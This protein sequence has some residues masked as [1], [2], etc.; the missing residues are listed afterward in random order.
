M[1]NV[2]QSSRR[3]IGEVRLELARIEW[4]KFHEFLGATGV[5]VFVVLLFSIYLFAV[6]HTIMAVAKQIFARGL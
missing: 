4:P 2:V 3:F 5:V 1:K 6:D